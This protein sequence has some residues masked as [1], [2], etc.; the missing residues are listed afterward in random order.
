MA[1]I[2]DEPSVLD[3]ELMIKDQ[4]FQSLAPQEQVIA[5]SKAMERLYGQ[6]FTSLEP[7][8]QGQAIEAAINEFRPKGWVEWGV[9]Q[10]PI[11]G[12]A[13]GEMLFDRPARPS[14]LTA[15][16]VGREHA[17]R[18][19]GLYKG[20]EQV[21]VMGGVIGTM[22]GASVGAAALG[23]GGLAAWLGGSATLSIP[24]YLSREALV[25][26]I[27]EVGNFI[28]EPP[29]NLGEAALRIGTGAA[30]MTG[31]GG[32]TLAKRAVVDRIRGSMTYRDLV[33]DFGGKAQADDFLARYS[34]D[35][36]NAVSYEEL[37]ILALRARRPEDIS[38]VKQAI[39]TKLQF[40][41]DVVSGRIAELEAGR[42]RAEGEQRA[43]RTQAEFETSMLEEDMMLKRASDFIKERELAK[44]EE[45]AIHKLA[46]ERERTLPTDADK[47]YQLQQRAQQIENDYNEVLSRNARL[48]DEEAY[49][50]F[51][52]GEKD[53]A[54]LI[55]LLVKVKEN[56]PIR[57]RE[58][59]ANLQKRLEQETARREE[60]KIES[61][62]LSRQLEDTRM[63]ERLREADLAA[64]ERIASRQGREEMLTEE[65]SQRAASQVESE[66][67]ANKL[68]EDRINQQLREA[69]LT[70]Q[71]RIALN[72]QSTAMRQARENEIARVSEGLSAGQ[73]ERLTERETIE[74]PKMPTT[75]SENMLIQMLDDPLEGRNGFVGKEPV[76]LP[77]VMMRENA[78]GVEAVV[79]DKFNAGQ[80]I[81]RGGKGI[82]PRTELR[83]PLGELETRTARAI[84]LRDNV[85]PVPTREEA[86]QI[87]QRRI[88][89]EQNVRLADSHRVRPDFITNKSIQR[90]EFD[91]R[92]SAA[93]NLLE[94]TN[95]QFGE[96]SQSAFRNLKPLE[97]N[98]IISALEGLT[99]KEATEIAMALKGAGFEN[100]RLSMNPQGTID[101]SLTR[102]TSALENEAASLFMRRS[103]KKG[104]FDPSERSYSS[105][106]QSEQEA[107]GRAE[108]FSDKEITKYN[109]FINDTLTDMSSRGIRVPATTEAL[110]IRP[111]EEQV[112]GRQARADLLPTAAIASA[113]RL[114]RFEI[115]DIVKMN[116][117]NYQ[118]FSEVKINGERNLVL[119]GIDKDTFGMQLA[120]IAEE[121][122][123]MGGVIREPAKPVGREPNWKG[124]PAR[125]LEGML[126]PQTL[127]VA[128]PPIN[129]SPSAVMT[130]ARSEGMSASMAKDGSITV[131]QKGIKFQFNDVE[132]AARFVENLRYKKQQVDKIIQDIGGKECL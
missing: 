22:Y 34:G 73:L 120:P 28:F 130:A 33:R 29:E 80:A 81:L 6:K 118:I 13:L 117:K 68:R 105:L 56:E 12:P 128:E 32:A 20:L 61:E 106:S 16:I 82:V 91:L 89:A 92:K 49:Q 94:A 63:Q 4:R 9:E 17:N 35:D 8:K 77:M 74:R 26:S 127:P 47:R 10:T 53:G 45:L 40:D 3:L 109:K 36:V 103:Y 70:A 38:N 57:Q 42:A 126:N 97:E 71:E 48:L 102:G 113:E 30:F 87:L 64:Q 25:G 41:A 96:G 131:T 67:L 78:E 75:R 93:E 108:G 84:G 2:T 104:I 79:V 69:N 7:M 129:R 66:L 14:E 55:N 123:R 31:F 85:L 24:S 52:N 76:T 112:L 11:V 15:D 119:E 58:I 50:K 83:Q 86:V 95:R 100:V 60:A 27:F 72:E 88:E 125:D 39:E 110:G 98:R 44:Q 37:Q 101:I 111:I 90:T 116:G 122:L 51:L 99:D 46:L 62:K 124:S 121:H 18:Y 132:D 65:T 114:K 21:V 107:L 43:I 23:L 54:G 59:N 19:G 5:T 1:E 115:G